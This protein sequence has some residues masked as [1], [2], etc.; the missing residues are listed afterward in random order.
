[1]APER[2]V[3]RAHVVGAHLVAEPARARVDQDRDLALAQAEL[4]RGRAVDQLLDALDLD[5]V[6]ARADRAELAGAPLARPRRDVPGVGALEAALGLGRADVV[7]AADP[8]LLDE[9]PRPLLEHR[10]ELGA[11]QRERP[12]LARAGGHAPRDRL[13]ERAAAAGV[14]LAVRERGREQPHAAVDVVADAAGGDD[15]VRR[16]GRGQAADRE[17]VALVDVGHRDRGLDDPRQRRDVLQLLE[18]AVGAD[19][20]EQV[21]VGEHARGHAHVLPRV[22]RDLPEGVVDPDGLRHRARRSRASRRGH[23]AA[24]GRGR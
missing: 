19:R 5:E 13:D 23:G 7:V 24:R 12:A 21:G 4:L 10:V 15:A 20:G 16:R 8:A 14:E 3:H 2:R 18:R 9:P 6:V 11:A 1:M 22:G 17:A